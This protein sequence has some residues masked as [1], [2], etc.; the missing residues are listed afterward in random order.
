MELLVAIFREEDGMFMAECPLIPGRV[1]QGRTE[2][3][4]RR[5]SGKPSRCA[6]RSGR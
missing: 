5:T 6:S 2:K 3:K 4:L 1:S